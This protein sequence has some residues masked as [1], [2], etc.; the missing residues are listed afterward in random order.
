VNNPARPGGGSQR[1]FHCQSV[2]AERYSGHSHKRQKK[3]PCV[4]ENV[5]TESLTFVLHRVSAPSTRPHVVRHGALPLRQRPRTRPCPGR[6]AD[7]DRGT[8]QQRRLRPRVEQS[9]H[10]RPVVARSVAMNT[11]RVPEEQLQQ[12]QHAVSVPVPVSYLPLCPLR[13]FSSSLEDTHIACAQVAADAV[14]IDRV[15]RRDT[16]TARLG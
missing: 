15:V 13:S 1:K 12:T 9:L 10:L 8:Q 5:N 3:D 2:P 14:A 4:P 7:I 11:A 16:A 6:H